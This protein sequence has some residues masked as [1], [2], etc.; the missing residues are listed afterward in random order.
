MARVATWRTV[1]ELAQ[2][3]EIEQE[4]LALQIA[5]LRA[6]QDPQTAAGRANIL[7]CEYLVRGATNKAAD[8]A[9]SKGWKHPSSNKGVP[10]MINYTAKHIQ[11]FIDSPPEGVSP[12]LADLCCKVLARQ[13]EKNRGD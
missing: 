3:L 9:N 1:E 10:S 13:R 11:Q 2:I 8:W 6:T 5:A 4:S 12:A 7:L